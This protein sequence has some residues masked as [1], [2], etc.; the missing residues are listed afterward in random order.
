VRDDELARKA[1]HDAWLAKQL[2][3]PPW[4]FSWGTVSS[5]YDATFCQSLVSVVYR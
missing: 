4:S 3:L 1:R 5:A 2:G